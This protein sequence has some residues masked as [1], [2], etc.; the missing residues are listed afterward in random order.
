MPTAAAPR[1]SVFIPTYNRQDLIGDAVGSVL[2]QTFRDFE[3]IVVDDGSTDRTCEIVEAFGDPRV[4]LVSNGANLGIPVSRNRGLEL[5]RGEYLAILDSDDRMLPDRLQR[6][7]AFLGAHSDIALIGSW[8]RF[9]DDAGRPTGRRRIQPV[10]PADVDA[11]LLFRCCISNRSVM[12]RTEIMRAYGY[13]PA[14][15][16]C[17]DY[18]LFVRMSGR[19]R[20]ANLP[21]ILV[22]ARQHSGQITRATF[23][24]GDRLKQRIAG[25]QLDELGVHYTE[26]DL[27]AHV[28]LSRTRKSG[29][30][31][32]RALLDWAEPW[33]ASLVEANRTSARY[34]ARALANAA[35]EVW[36]KLCAGAFAGGHRPGLSRFFRSTLR[37]GATAG[38]RRNLAA[39]VTRRFGG[40]GRASA[41]RPG[42]S[43]TARG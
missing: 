17:Q 14:F 36:L 16:R 37:H 42:V 28:G 34:D 32:D 11:T 3:L 25:R 35:A 22:E 43:S 40:A 29:R 13:D 30:V 39:A 38:Y 21:E 10:D 12:G 23:D 4:R 31:P 7:V 19:H 27:V 6:Q 9:I 41:A 2:A 26:S 5:A 1:V 18:D 15:I 20:M 33:L 8:A 24:I